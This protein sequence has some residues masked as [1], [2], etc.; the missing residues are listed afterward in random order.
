M[1]L[2]DKIKDFRDSHQNPVIWLEIEEVKEF[3]RKIKSRYDHSMSWDKFTN[4]INE[5]AGEGLI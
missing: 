3:I 5:E 4:M 1:I 2:S